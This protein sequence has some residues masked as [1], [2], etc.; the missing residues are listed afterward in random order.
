M[1]VIEP[2][3]IHLLTMVFALVILGMLLTTI[4][5]MEN[6]HTA[7]ERTIIVN[8]GMTSDEAARYLEREKII[9]NAFFFKAY[10][11]LRRIDNKVRAGAYILSNAMTFREIA[12]RITEMDTSGHNVTVP[13]GYNVVQIAGLLGE[14]QLAEREKFISLAK[15]RS[16]FENQLYVPVDSIEGYLFPDTYKIPKG[17]DEKTV[18]SLMIDRFRVLVV[19]K[20]MNEVKK[21]GKS[22]HEII[23][24]ASIVEK[25]AKVDRERPVIAAVFLNRLKAGKKL[26]SCASV[27]YALGEW[28]AKLTFNDLKVDSPYNTYIHEGLPPGPICSPGIASIKAALN[29]AD[30]DYLFFVSKQD[31]KGTHLFSNSLRTHRNAARHYQKENK[32][33]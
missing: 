22:L 6:K 12:E 1:D 3:K 5:L 19:E 27:Q 20:I 30:V 25:E 2:K 14:L 11:K 28:K 31:G 18:V 15:D 29:P 23:T 26:E 13:E 17:L 7:V 16:F 4:L 24:L 8:F 21:S 33:K 32:R 10:L 9:D